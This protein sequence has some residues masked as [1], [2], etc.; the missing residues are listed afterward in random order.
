MNV[1]KHP[2]LRYCYN[3]SLSADAAVKVELDSSTAIYHDVERLVVDTFQT[4]LVGAGND[5]V[6][7]SHS[8]I[9]VNK[10]CR[11]ENAKLYRKYCLKVKEMCRS[12]S[13]QTYP[14]VDGLSGEA[15]V[16]TRMLSKQFVPFI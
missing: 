6:G 16:A 4:Q 2:L 10:I 9:A 5:A 8:S 13:T 11:V 1:P 3:S 12:A 15:E 14:P 7:L